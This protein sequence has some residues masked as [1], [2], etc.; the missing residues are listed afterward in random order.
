MHA[1]LSSTCRHTLSTPV[2]AGALPM[3]THVNTYQTRTKDK[4]M[5]VAYECLQLVRSCIWFDVYIVQRRD[6]VPECG[7][8]CA[9]TE[10]HQYTNLVAAVFYVQLQFLR[11]K[12]NWPCL[13]LDSRKHL[14]IYVQMWC[15]VAIQARM[16]KDWALTQSGLAMH[17]CV[18][19]GSIHLCAENFWLHYAMHV[20]MCEKRWIQLLRGAALPSLRMHAWKKTH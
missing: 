2:L 1:Q 7:H 4:C 5:C 17:A 16:N 13:Q 18:N 3:Y 10:L 9:L 14:S 15:R 11:F 19:K 6:M 12:M 20:Y 8:R